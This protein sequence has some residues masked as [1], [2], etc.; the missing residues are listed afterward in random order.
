MKFKKL[1]NLLLIFT[2]L[3]SINLSLN[4]FTPS[5]HPDPD[6]CDDPANAG[7]DLDGDGCPD[8]P[9]SHSSIVSPCN[10]SVAH[11]FIDFELKSIGWE[12]VFKRT[13]STQNISG[14]ELGMGWNHKLAT[15]LGKELIVELK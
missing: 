8:C 11:K 6:P 15:I 3:F 13:Y 4:A 9:V 7:V 14:G 2:L 5:D 1:L 12:I 10:G